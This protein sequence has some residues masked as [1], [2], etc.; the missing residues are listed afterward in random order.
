MSLSAIMSA[1][2][3][4]W[5]TLGLLVK[6][7]IEERIAGTRYV[8]GRILGRPVLLFLSG[9]SMINAA[10]TAE[11]AI[12][13]YGPARLLFSGIAGG[14]DPKLG[15]G[16]VVVPGRWAQPLEATFAREGPGGFAPPRDGLLASPA[17]IP[18]FGMIH[19]RQ[20]EVPGERGPEWRRWFDANAALLAV[21]RDASLQA[22]LKHDDRL[23][24][25]PAIHV[26]GSGVSS[27]VFVD[28]AAYH[29]HLFTA[30]GARVV[31]MESAAVA[32]VASAHGL[33]FVALRSVSDLAGGDPHPNRWHV[34]AAHAADNSAALVTA[35]LAHLP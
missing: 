21:V 24:R 2:E 25:L 3:P 16:D 31:D 29:D 6:D 30:W 17:D 18:G 26:G 9:M 11:R 32:Q 14:L 34:F 1:Y 20:V 19:A 8:S 23:G 13:R 22:V 27:P 28:N 15:V 10:M 5:R 33:P 12:Q 7:P 35:M 4:E